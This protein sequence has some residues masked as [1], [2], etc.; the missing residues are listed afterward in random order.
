MNDLF[1]L[2]RQFE[3]INMPDADVSMLHEVEMPLPYNMMLRKLIDQTIW[4]QESVKIYGKDYQNYGELRWNYGDSAPNYC[5]AGP[6]PPNLHNRILFAL[7][8][9]L[10]L[11]LIFCLTAARSPSRGGVV[12]KR[13]VLFLPYKSRLFRLFR[14]PLG[15][16]LGLG[17]YRAARPNAPLC[18]PRKPLGRHSGDGHEIRQI[19]DMI[20]SRI[21]PPF[22][23]MNRHRDC[24]KQPAKPPS[25]SALVPRHGMGHQRRACGPRN[26]EAQPG[27]VHR[28]RIGLGRFG[29]RIA[30]PQRVQQ[31]E[32]R[33]RDD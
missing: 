6:T 5:S 24:E 7:P 20:P 3:P 15:L 28:E 29:E 23:K 26:A 18:S 14:R 25:G 8:G 31:R 2:D 17:A 12:Q 22:V 16:G 4:R 32:A 13:R 10:F 19:N 1:T 21:V 30:W 33:D 11:R 27:D 9:G